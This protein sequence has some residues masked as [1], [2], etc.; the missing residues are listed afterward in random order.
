[1]IWGRTPRDFVIH[2]GTRGRH[3]A[4]PAPPSA[5]SISSRPLCAIPRHGSG[6]M[7]CAGGVKPGKEQAGIKSALMAWGRGVMW[8]TGA[9][10]LPKDA[11]AWPELAVASAP[12]LGTGQVPAPQGSARPSG[13]FPMDFPLP[14]PPG[15]GF[16]P[17]PSSCILL[18][19]LNARFAVWCHP[20]GWALPTPWGFSLQEMRSRTPP[21]PLW[22]GLG[23]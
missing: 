22:A 18:S 4:N 8:L 21:R 17:S 5:S 2:G 10:F 11:G 1:M 6:R 9:G 13:S 14:H 3:G 19:R 12:W 16:T 7:C 20:F 15:Q 23:S